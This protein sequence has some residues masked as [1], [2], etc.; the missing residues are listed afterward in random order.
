MTVKGF[1]GALLT[2]QGDLAPFVAAGSTLTPE[3]EGLYATFSVERVAVN[4]EVGAAQD[5][6][7]RADGLE[8][9]ARA[10][11]QTASGVSMPMDFPLLMSVAGGHWQ[12]DR[13]N[14]APGHRGA[15]SHLTSRRQPLIDNA[16]T[17]HRCASE[18]D[19]QHVGRTLNQ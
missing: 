3:P 7:Q 18:F 15:T 16:V 14:D 8:V 17:H 4:S 19:R 5:V 6:P 12:V 11:V 2:R 1:L 13:I 9:T 10:I